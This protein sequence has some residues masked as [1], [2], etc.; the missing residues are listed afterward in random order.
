MRFSIRMTLRRVADRPA[1]ARRRQAQPTLP[2]PPDQPTVPARDLLLRSWP[3]RLFMVAF[4]VKVLVAL[5]RVFAEPPVFL[6]VLS[7]TA[8]LALLVALGYF[9]GRLFLL[10]KRRLLWRVR[11][12]LILSY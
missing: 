10:V 4:G 5:V 8:T 6:Q 1:P 3:G 11:R 12:K 2:L 9:V 7:T